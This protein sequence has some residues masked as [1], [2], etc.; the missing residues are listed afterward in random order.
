MLVQSVAARVLETALKT[1]GDFAEIFL[2]DTLSS[3]ISMQR[4]RIENATTQRRYGAGVRVYK[5]LRS[6]Y[7]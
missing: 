1:G 6:V 7:A 2:E 4:S 5:G 3:G